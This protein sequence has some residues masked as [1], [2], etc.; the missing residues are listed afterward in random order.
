MSPL[1][2]RAM[3][4]L[5]GYAVVL[6]IGLVLVFKVLPAFGLLGPT[7]AEEIEATSR[8]L[9]TAKVYGAEAGLPSLEAALAGL[10]QARELLAAGHNRSAKQAALEAREH[11]LDAQREALARREDERRRAR[12]I[13]AEIDHLLSDLE[14]LYSKAAEGK[15][16]AATGHLLLV[17]R[18]AR[19]TGAALF[20]AFEQG[21]FRK[22]ISEG[23]AAKAHLGEAKVNLEAAR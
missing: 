6:A 22:V 19:E 11:A 10:K 20:L 1:V 14:E 17:M 7:A 3:R 2:V 4:R 5:A 12:Q 9:D 16:K 18:D 23:D 13:V 8:A 21:N 15:D